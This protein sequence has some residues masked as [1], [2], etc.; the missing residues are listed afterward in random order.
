MNMFYRV[1]NPTDVR[2]MSEQMLVWRQTDNPK[3]ND[4]LPQPPPPAANAIWQDGTWA[5]P[6]PPPDYKIW[7]NSQAFLSEFTMQEMAAISLS[8][9]ETIAAL[10]LLLSVWFSEVHSNDPRVIT[11]LDKLME[12]NI[13][14]EDRKN[15]ILSKQ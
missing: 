6:P 3:A 5:L 10:R 14:T 11:S 2:D 15:E 9:D 12:L 13:I 7:P 8:T 4:W 1:S